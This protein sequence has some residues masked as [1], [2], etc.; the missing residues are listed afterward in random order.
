MPTSQ[1]NQISEIIHL[2][3][4]TNP[5]KLLDI[6]VGFGKY[7][8]LSREYLEL[9]DRRDNIYDDWK[10]RIDGI[11]VFVKYI[12]PVHNLIYNNIYIGNAIDILPTL[13]V[14]YDLILLVDV[15]EHFHCKDGLLLL[16]ECEKRS[17]NVLISVP[18]D[19]NPQEDSFGNPY[20]KHKFQWEK[21]HFKMFRN[22]FF[23]PNIGGSLII[24]FGENAKDIL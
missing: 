20:E 18:I 16:Q 13:N 3:Y 14:K 7:G 10:R 15:L 11:E 24:Y 8:Y 9:W 1:Y 6:G 17:R 4:L 23:L 2:I 21:K 22:K 5:E 19:M 12:S